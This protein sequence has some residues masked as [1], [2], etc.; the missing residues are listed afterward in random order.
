MYIN[1]IFLNYNLQLNKNYFLLFIPLSSAISPVN[2]GDGKLEQIGN[3][4]YIFISLW[5][6]FSYRVSQETWQLVNSFQCLLPWHCTNCLLLQTFA[7][8]FVKKIFY[9]KIYLFEINFTKILLLYKFLIIIFGVK[10]L[11]K[12]WKKTF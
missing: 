1:N 7:V 4:F 11:Y 10:Q 5:C 12:L 2:L 6:R 8:Q 9:S 3:L